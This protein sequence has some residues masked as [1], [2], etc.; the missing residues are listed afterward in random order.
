MAY[1]GSVLIRDAPLLNM[2][3]TKKVIFILVMIWQMPDIKIRHYFV[4]LN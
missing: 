2:V 4:L 3:I 1:F